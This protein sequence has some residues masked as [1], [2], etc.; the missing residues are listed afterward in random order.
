MEHF[1]LVSQAQYNCK[2][3]VMVDEI[4][5]LY[6]GRYCN[7]RQ[8]M[9]EKPVKFGIKVWALTSS[10]SRYVSNLIVYLDASD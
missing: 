8:Y 9:K 1:S 6:K 5:V 3:I 4:M 7:I 2:E 10:K